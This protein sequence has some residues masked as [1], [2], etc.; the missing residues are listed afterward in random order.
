MLQN[1]RCDCRVQR[2]ELLQHCAATALRRCTARLRRLL[3]EN[4]SR[5]PGRSHGCSCVWDPRDRLQANLPAC[6][7]VRIAVLADERH[8]GGEARQQS[9]DDDGD[10]DG[11]ELANEHQVPVLQLDRGYGGWHPRTNAKSRL[12]LR[13][14]YR[15]HE[16]KHRDHVPER[17]LANQLEHGR[18]EHVCQL[19]C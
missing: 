19:G 13:K 5:K 3:L 12:W 10:G 14:R 9:C 18:H 15:V 7:S 17:R 16:Y 2:V 4:K 8:H 11:Q 6:T 1:V